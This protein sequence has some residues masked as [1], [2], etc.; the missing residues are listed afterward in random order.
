MPCSANSLMREIICDGVFRKT[1]LICVK[2]ADLNILLIDNYDSFTYNIVDTLRKLHYST[3]QVLKN[4][5][6]TPQI[7]S[8]YDCILLSP[9]PATPSESGNLLAVLEYLKCSHPIL[10]ICL[11]HQAIAE[12]FGAELVNLTRPY[13]GF[14]THLKKVE[15][16][17]ILPEVESIQVG[18]YHSWTVAPQ[19]FPSELCI[20][21]YSTEG[22]IMSLRHRE[23]PIHGVQ[24]HPESYMTPMGAL[25]LKKFL[26]GIVL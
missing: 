19:N 1:N 25:M 8:N 23:L 9:G 15:A 20:T 6:A 26:E 11:G 16:D 12:V 2:I 7:A 22:H 13:H 4:D 24:F 21:S 18:L 3:I 14:I 17:S 5:E 10:G